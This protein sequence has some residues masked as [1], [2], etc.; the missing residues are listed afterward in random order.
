MQIIRGLNCKIV[1]EKKKGKTKAM[2]QN[3]KKKKNLYKITRIRK[4]TKSIN[5]RSYNN[6]I[7]SS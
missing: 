1:K 2:Q 6:N 7:P 5:E 4:T 3:Q